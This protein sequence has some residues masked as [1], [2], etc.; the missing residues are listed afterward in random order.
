[1]TSYRRISGQTL[2]REVNNNGNIDVYMNPIGKG[3]Y[4]RLNGVITGDLSVSGN[5]TLAGTLNV[6]KISLTDNLADALSITEG[7]NTYIK[8][9]TTDTAEQITINR[10]TLFSGSGFGTNPVTIT[11][12]ALTV[13]VALNVTS[14]SINKTSA[15]VNID[16]TGVTT[17]QSTPT[18]TVATSATTNAGAGVARFTANSLTA[19]NA[20]SISATGLTTGSA[21]NITGVANKMGINVETG[22]SRFNGGTIEQGST[23]YTTGGARSITAAELIN[24]FAYIGAPGGAVALTFPGASTATTGVQ[25]VLAAMGITSAAGTRLPPIIVAATGANNLTVTAGAGE[26]IYGTAAINNKNAIINYIFTGAA[27]AAIIVTT[28]V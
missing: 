6:N 26:T 12:N 5:T 19:G 14:F 11:G 20:V 27:T 2:N 10:N 1:M 21:L 3:V 15:L 17:N 8:I 13:G 9:A 22:V 16:Q 24:G 28:S 7:I 18:L 25:A 4:P 23:V